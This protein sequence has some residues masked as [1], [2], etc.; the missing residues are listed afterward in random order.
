MIGARFL[1]ILATYLLRVLSRRIRMDDPVPSWQAKA[2]IAWS[3]MRGAVSLAAALA[4]P[5]TTDAGDAVP[6]PRPDHLPHLRRHPR[7]AR[8]PGP[9]A[10]GR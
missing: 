10:A 9:D 2:V 5:L 4:L 1:W 3:G 8:P 7:H 6:R